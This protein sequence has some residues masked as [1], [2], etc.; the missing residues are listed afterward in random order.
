M[1]GRIL[2]TGSSGYL[3][4]RVVDLLAARGGFEIHGMDVRMPENRDRYT[5]FIKGSVVNARA[6][7][8]L[9]DVARPDVAIHLAFVVDSTHD[10]RLE[11]SV[12]VEGARNFLAN[13]ERLC[14]PKVIFLSSAA[15]Y[16]AHDDNDVPLTESSPVRGVDGYSYSRLKAA[17]DMI[18]QEYMAS[19]ADCDFVLL[20]PCLFVGPNTR[21]NFF[22]ILKFALVPQIIDGK[23]LRDPEFQFIHEDD[24]AQCV[25]GA[26]DKP[27]RG[28]F[29]VAAGGSTPFS[30]LV[31][32]FGKRRIAVPNWIIYPVVAILWRLHLVSSPPAQLDFIRYQ[33]LLDASRMRRDLY[34]PSK[35]SIEAFDEFARTHR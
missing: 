3:G 1:S 12:A 11:E 28:I 10:S 16:G 27:V 18:A 20:R 26:I 8:D 32:R 21:N 35:S 2:I 19:H 31:R 24:M 14:V 7:R 29:N 15:A 17:A 4:T 13:C 25:A 5:C 22:D 23:G 33:W 30:E 34:I 9:F 6:M